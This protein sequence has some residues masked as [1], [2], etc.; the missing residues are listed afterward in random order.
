MPKVGTAKTIPAVLL[1]PALQTQLR[2]RADKDLLLHYHNSPL[3]ICLGQ[4]EQDLKN[5]K[6]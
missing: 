2:L 3:C 1:D 6:S 4:L 5:S